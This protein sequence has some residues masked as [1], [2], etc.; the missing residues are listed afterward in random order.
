MINHPFY[1]NGN[2]YLSGGMQ[3]TD[4]QGSG[5]RAVCAKKLT[6]LGFNP[7]DIAALD[8]AYSANHGQLYRFVSDEE[9]LQRKSNIRKHFIDADI[10]LVRQ[11]SD[12]IIIYYD[13]SVRRGAGT[14]SEVHDA[15]M[16]DIPIF[17]V[18]GYKKLNEVPG[19]MQ[20][21]TTVIFN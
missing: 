15:F 14:T 12:A 10:K 6:N 5:W 3:F 1:P 21:Q 2:V 19:W 4:D 17:L 8:I 16:M 20:A 18:N 13:E 9:L 11:D 7:I